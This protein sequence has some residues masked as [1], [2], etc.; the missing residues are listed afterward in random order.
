M[1]NIVIGMLGQKL[2]HQGLGKR[3]WQRW[4]PNVAILM[5]NDFKVDHFILIHHEDEEELADLTVRDMHEVSPNTRITTH[6]VDY[7]N[8]WDFEQVYAQLHDFS[9][10]Y[11]FYPEQANYYVHITTGTHVAQIC[12]Y[13]LTEANYVPGKLLQTRAGKE[14]RAEGR[15]QIIDLDLSCYDL[16]ASRFAHESREGVAYLKSGIETRNEAFNSLI[17]QVEKVSIRSAE[18]ILLTGPTGVGKSRLA[19]RIFELKKQRGQVSGNLVEVNCAT[20]RGDNAMSALFGHIKGSYTGAASERMGL[21]READKGLLFLDEIGELGVDEQAMLLRAIEEKTFMPFGSDKETHSDFQL[22]AGTNR[23]LFECVKKG[24]FREDLLARIN[25]WTYEMLSLKNRIEDLEPNINHELEVFT[26][27][28]GHKVSFNK[29]AR[30]Q[31]LKFAH[32][33]AALWRANFRDLNSSIIRM[34]TLASGGRINEAI[35]A[36]EIKRLSYDWQSYQPLSQEDSS[37]EQLEEIV[38]DEVFEQMDLFDQL[39]LTEVV[40]VCK[41]SR[42]LA[43]AGRILF[44]VS[45][46]AKTN[47]NDS[48]R[49]RLY[50][51]KFGLSFKDLQRDIE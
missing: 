25:L 40:K 27:K 7:E 43:E 48:H 20:L 12:L 1:D 11:P 3:R 51:K 13:L 34:A 26:R 5:Q 4:R 6:V 28:A 45:R 37:K 9:R 44:H 8:P 31:Y 41:K 23:N 47:A 38:G 15:V 39:Q 10:F 42:S 17:S 2:D 33:D 46:E 35:V 18:P 22:I 21:L 36:Q 16:I 19:K 24:E 29:G 50:L 49:L 30:E 32:C 14:K